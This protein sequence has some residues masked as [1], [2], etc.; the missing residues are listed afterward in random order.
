M[1]EQIKFIL[2]NPCYLGK[3]GDAQ[4]EF[5]PYDSSYLEKVIALKPTV[6]LSNYNKLNYIGVLPQNSCPKNKPYT[7]NGVCTSCDGSTPFY[8]TNLK[9]CVNCPAGKFFSE[10][11]HSC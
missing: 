1:K 8:D 7:V 4:I 3:L 9:I 11:T 6:W 5:S 10:A 2:L